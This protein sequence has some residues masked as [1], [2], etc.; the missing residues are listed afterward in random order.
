MIQGTEIHSLP[1]GCCWHSEKDPVRRDI[2]KK[3]G[4][5]PAIISVTFPNHEPYSY[6]RVA[7]KKRVYLTFHPENL[8]SLEG[9]MKG[10]KM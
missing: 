2:S 4:P 9:K 1:S 3:H 10:R 8:L 5:I 7:V 6:H